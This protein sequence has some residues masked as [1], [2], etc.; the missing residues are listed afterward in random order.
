MRLAVI[1][2]VALGVSAQTKSFVGTVTGF[3]PEAAEVEVKP[4][5]GAAV[6]TLSGLTDQVFAVAISPEGNQVA[7]G[8]YNGEVAVWTIADGKLVK[9][10]NASPGYVAA[11]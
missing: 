7:A 1:F 8:S 6:K 5:N 10:F 3:K 4:D 11:K 2:L 9:M